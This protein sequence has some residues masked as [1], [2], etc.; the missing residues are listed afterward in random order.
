MYE[1][2]LRNS[3]VP[4]KFVF[5]ESLCVYTLK[6]GWVVRT[7]LHF[8]CG[9]SIKLEG[10]EPQWAEPRRLPARRFSDCGAQGAGVPQPPTWGST[11]Q[12]L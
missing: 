9:F 2:E 12:R 7:D 6:R 4:S 1:G 5:A 8:L 10:T 11:H 3:G